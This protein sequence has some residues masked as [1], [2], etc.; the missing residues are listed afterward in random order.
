MV[1]YKQEALDVVVDDDA[2]VIPRQP[3]TPISL[4]NHISTIGK[5]AKKFFT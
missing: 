3:L 1:Q 5:R 2:P 4:P